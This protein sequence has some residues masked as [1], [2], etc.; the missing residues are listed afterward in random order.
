MQYSYSAMSQCCYT[1]R[2]SS[3]FSQCCYLLIHSLK[4]DTGTHVPFAQNPSVTCQVCGRSL[5]NWYVD[6][7]F[8]SLY[9]IF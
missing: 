7:T 3:A 1:L 4:M 6:A 2:Q 5:T 8:V 9:V